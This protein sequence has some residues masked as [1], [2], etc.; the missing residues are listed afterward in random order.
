MS[1]TFA[2]S[3][4]VAV[5]A[6]IISMWINGVGG[7]IKGRYL[8]G[9]MALLHIFEGVINPI[10]HGMRIWANIFA[11]EILIGIML[12]AGWAAS[13]PLAAWMGF[14]LF[15]GVMQAYVFTVLANVYMGEKINLAH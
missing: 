5:G 2:M 3:I 14:S 15:V 13:I 8:V 7:Y 10:T 6:I 11:G 12:Q 4:G 9:P 1:V